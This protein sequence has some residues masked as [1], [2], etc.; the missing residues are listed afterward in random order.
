[1]STTTKSCPLELSRQH[2]HKQGNLRSNAKL[3]QINRKVQIFWNPENSDTPGPDEGLALFLD[4]LH[5]G[6]I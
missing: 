2:G 4:K 1:M 5:I 3:R 6:Q